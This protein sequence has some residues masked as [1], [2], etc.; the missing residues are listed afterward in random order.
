MT[1]SPNQEVQPI[2]CLYNLCEPPGYDYKAILTF[3]ND[4]ENSTEIMINFTFPDLWSHH[5]EGS[6]KNSRQSFSLWPEETAGMGEN[7]NNLI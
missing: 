7:C 3:S 4:E 2:A 6:E 5:C 1:R